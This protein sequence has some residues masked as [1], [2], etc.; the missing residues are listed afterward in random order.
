MVPIQTYLHD[1]STVNEPGT[2]EKT[3]VGTAKLHQ[4]V[5]IQNLEIKAKRKHIL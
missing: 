1:E 3:E 5:V 2:L 4:A